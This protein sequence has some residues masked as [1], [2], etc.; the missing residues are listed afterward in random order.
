MCC[1]SPSPINYSM[2]NNETIFGQNLTDKQFRTL[3][4]IEENNQAEN[5][6]NFFFPVTATTRLKE[7][8]WRC[9][10]SSAWPWPGGPSVLMGRQ[11][12]W[13]SILVV[14]PFLA[15]DSLGSREASHV[16]PSV[17]RSII[18][19]YGFCFRN[20]FC[21]VLQFLKFKI[22]ENKILI[23]IYINT[24]NRPTNIHHN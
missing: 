2:N 1:L 24:Q 5:C 7:H 20:L 21:R 18:H 12:R 17:V 6:W 3:R 23:I 10:V 13:A 9:S 16:S 22:Q 4:K 14:A 15:D 19:C 8:Q 11:Y